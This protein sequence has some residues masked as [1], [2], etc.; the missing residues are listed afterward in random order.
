MNDGSHPICVPQLPLSDF[1]GV[2]CTDRH[3]TKD[4]TCHYQ[5]LLDGRRHCL[6]GKTGQQSPSVWICRILRAMLFFSS[7]SLSQRAYGVQQK[8]PV[9]RYNMP[10]A[11]HHASGVLLVRTLPVGWSGCIALRRATLQSYPRVIHMWSSRSYF[12]LLTRSFALCR[13]TI[14]SFSLS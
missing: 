10:R 7:I 3:L 11:I 2:R 14:H 5:H 6:L 13:S 1:P 12:R 4:S 9:Q 8:H